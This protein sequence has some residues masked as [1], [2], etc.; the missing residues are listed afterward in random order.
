MVIVTSTV[1]YKLSMSSNLK[2][3]LYKV[4]V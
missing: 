2:K 4:K 1:T 3:P